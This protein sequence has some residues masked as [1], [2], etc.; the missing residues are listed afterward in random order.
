MLIREEAKHCYAFGCSAGRGIRSAETSL[1][2][3]EG[4][5]AVTG[6]QNALQSST[7]DTVDILNCQGKFKNL[8][9]KRAQQSQVHNAMVSALGEN[10]RRYSNVALVA[11]ADEDG[12]HIKVLAIAALMH[13]FPSLCTD[14]RVLDAVLPIAQ[15]GSTPAYTFAQQRRISNE[16][17]CSEKES[18][19]KGVASYCDKLLQQ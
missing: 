4:D 13:T 8:T 14:E 5:S 19:F 1:L 11:D 6:V 3:I 15:I 12:L 9:K 17:D 7:R 18:Y 10:G 16:S 2:I